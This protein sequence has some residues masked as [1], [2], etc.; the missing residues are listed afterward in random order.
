M[1]D[2]AFIMASFSAPV[3]EVLVILFDKRSYV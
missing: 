3:G 1:D 2:S